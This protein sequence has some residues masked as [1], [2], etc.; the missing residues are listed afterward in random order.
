[1]A[2]LQQLVASRLAELDRSMR[3]AATKGDISVTTISNIVSGKHTGRVTDEIIAGLA[4][5]LDLSPRVV[6]EA[7]GRSSYEVPTEFVLPERAARLSAS[8]RRVLMDMMD[9]LLRAQE[10]ADNDIEKRDRL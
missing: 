1:M 8:S 4:Q 9:S 3:A 6:A 2:S 7:A 10:A 5:G